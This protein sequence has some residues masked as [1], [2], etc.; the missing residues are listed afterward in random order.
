[1]MGETRSGACEKERSNFKKVFHSW[2]QQA[3]SKGWKVKCIVCFR[4]NDVVDQKGFGPGAPDVI[5]KNGP[6]LVSL[7]RKGKG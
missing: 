2:Q 6:V 3:L 1:M 5:Q 7:A 4:G